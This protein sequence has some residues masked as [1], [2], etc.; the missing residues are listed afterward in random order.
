M[1]PLTDKLL[2]ICSNDISSIKPEKY[3]ASVYGPSLVDEL[4]YLLKKKMDFMGLSQPYKFFHM[5]KWAKK[6]A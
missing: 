4:S 6:S 3:I 2:S 5:K 1:R